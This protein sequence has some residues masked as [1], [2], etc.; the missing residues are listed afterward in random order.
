MIRKQPVF[1]ATLVYGVAARHASPN[2]RTRWRSLRSHQR[3]WERVAQP[4]E[5]VTFNHGVLGS[6]PSALTT[7]RRRIRRAWTGQDP[8]I[9]S[10]VVSGVDDGPPIELK[11]PANGKSSIT[12]AAAILCCN[13]RNSPRRRRPLHSA[14]RKHDPE[15]PLP[16]FP[17]TRVQPGGKTCFSNVR[18]RWRSIVEAIQR[19][20]ERVA[21]PVEHV[22]FNHG[23]L[24]SSPSALTNKIN[25]LS[26]ISTKSKTPRV[27][28]NVAAL[29][30]VSQFELRG[31]PA[32]A[33]A[34]GIRPTE[35][36]LEWYSTC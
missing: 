27:C 3:P 35:Y 6:S 14:S 30:G 29:G 17:V 7:A 16:V 28:K 34:L 4:V 15:T 11:I 36:M 31:N 1:R 25:D 26:P 23:V 18:R 5:H 20:W 22:T 19:P 24:E 2:V 10:H 8:V 13:R 32:A 33:V 12:S 9:K 21:Q